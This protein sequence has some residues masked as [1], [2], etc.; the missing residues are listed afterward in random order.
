M[1]REASGAAA[2]GAASIPAAGGATMLSAEARLPTAGEMALAGRTGGSRRATTVADVANAVSSVGFLSIL[3]AGS[4]YVPQDY[5]NSISSYSDAENDRLGEVLSGMDGVRVSRGPEGKGWA[6]SGSGGSGSG[7]EDGLVGGRV[8]RGTRRDARAL[9][10]DDL[11]GA[12]QPTASI[13]FD[14]INRNEGYTALAGAV[15]KRPPIPTTPEEKEMLRRKPDF[16]QGVINRHRIAI[17]DCYKRL[18]RTR[19]SLKGKVEVRFAINPEGRISWVEI[20]NSTIEEPELDS[21]ILLR[22]RNWNDFGFGDPT[23]PDEVYR[24]TFTFGF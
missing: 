17:T 3:T 15:D 14:K 12:L 1:T 19:P 9:N 11:I 5:I 18:L 21:C 10:V 6:G 7:S 24:Q 2:L 22:I 16:V 4:G 13:E 20:V 8:V 23:A